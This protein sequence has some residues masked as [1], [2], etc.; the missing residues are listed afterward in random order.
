VG[1]QCQF[2]V[3]NANS[4]LSILRLL[5]ARLT[6]FT[7]LARVCGGEVRC[8]FCGGDARDAGALMKPADD[9]VLQMWP[10]STRVNSSRANDDDPTLIDPVAR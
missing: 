3:V 1:Q 4:E 8:G 6:Y 2:R 10:L 7:P 5:S 9:D